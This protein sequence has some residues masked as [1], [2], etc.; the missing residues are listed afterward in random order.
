MLVD[1]ILFNNKK[2][3]LIINNIGVTVI[4]NFLFVSCSILK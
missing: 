2:K 1:I 4:L 3:V